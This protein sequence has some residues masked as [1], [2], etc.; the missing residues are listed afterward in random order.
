MSQRTAYFCGKWIDEGE[1]KIPIGDLGFSMGVTVTER[2]RTFGGRLFRK[3]EHLSRMRHSLEIVGMDA[4]GI[5]DEIDH[6]LDEYMERHQEMFAPGDDWAVITFAT[7][8]SG[9]GPT[10]AVHGAPLAFAEWAAQFRTG[11][12]TYVSRHR[13]VPPDCWP[14]QLKCRSRMHY[15]LADAEARGQNPAARAVLLDQEGFVGEGSTANLVVYDR[16]T[17]LATPKSSKVLPGVSVAVIAELSQELG[18][19]LEQRD[20][21]LDELRAADEVWLTSTSICML[22]VVSLDEQPVGEGKPGPM[23]DKF[24]AA[25]NS[26]VGID[27]ARQAE[28]FATR[29]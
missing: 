16:A 7:P 1:M 26:H 27:I 15:Y 22:P 3:S 23:Y 21:T 20:I 14:P 25:W 5:V 18:A 6:A 2:L 12:V 13:Q 28:Q 9:N 8:G 29:A 4:D 10:V 19:P 24:L 11:V 17:G